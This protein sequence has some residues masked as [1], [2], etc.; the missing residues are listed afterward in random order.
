MVDNDVV[1]N[2]KFNTLTTKANSLKKKIPDAT[3]LIYINQHNTDKPSLV[4]KIG[5]VDKKCQIQDYKCFIYK[6]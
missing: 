3:T 4:K 6:N 5:N 1:K 2:T